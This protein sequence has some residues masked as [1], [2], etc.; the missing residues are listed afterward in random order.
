MRQVLT[1]TCHRVEASR[2]TGYVGIEGL[3]ELLGGIMALAKQNLRP[4]CLD[5][6]KEFM[7]LRL[8]NLRVL[9]MTSVP[10][11]VRD[12]EFVCGFL[13]H[14]YNH[15]FPALASAFASIFCNDANDQSVL[16]DIVKHWLTTLVEGTHVDQ[17]TVRRS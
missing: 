16:G 1:M 6:V 3:L 13:M 14:H 4:P 10:S 15:I 17:Q 7:I 5:A 2:P 12:G 8:N 9:C 11:G